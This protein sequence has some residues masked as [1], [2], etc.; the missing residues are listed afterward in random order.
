MPL[1]SLPDIVRAIQTHFNDMTEI[2]TAKV[3]VVQKF[4]GGSRYNGYKCF[5]KYGN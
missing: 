2:C 4:I 3:E 1:S 5:L